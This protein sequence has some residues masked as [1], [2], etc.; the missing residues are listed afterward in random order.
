MAGYNTVPFLGLVSRVE[1][2]NVAMN[3]T[4]GWNINVE[5]DLDGQV[6]QGDIW[7]T[8]IAG[9]ARWSGSFSGDLVAGNTEQKA[10]IDNIVT[11]TPGAQLTDIKFLLDGST[12]A[13]TGNLRVA[14]MAFG[15]ADGRANFTCNFKSD[16][17]L[18]ITNAA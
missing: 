10:I 7:E 17:A 2:N 8:L 4:K 18:S 9:K 12:N 16:G 1:K 14:S 5:V 13:L 3:F 11:A 6:Y 15:A